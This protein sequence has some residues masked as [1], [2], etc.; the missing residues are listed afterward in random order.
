MDHCVKG[1]PKQKRV[2]QGWNLLNNWDKVWQCLALS[3]HTKVQCRFPLVALV[4]RFIAENRAANPTT[5]SVLYGCGIL[6][7]HPRFSGWPRGQTLW[8]RRFWQILGGQGSFKLL[9]EQPIYVFA[10]MCAVRSDTSL[11]SRRCSS[12]TPVN[13]GKHLTL[14]QRLK[15]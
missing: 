9:R 1:E 4:Q 3:P 2:E 15:I 10:L 14:T 13:R 6:C 11:L 7:F 8:E 5:S 12:G